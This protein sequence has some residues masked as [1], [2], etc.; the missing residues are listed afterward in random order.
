[1]L[2]PFFI[3]LATIAALG[4]S[5]TGQAANLDTGSRSVGKGASQ[6]TAPLQFQLFCLKHPQDC[7]ASSRSV[8][9]YT[10]KVRSMLSN[11]NSAVNR[12][13]RPLRERRDKWSLNPAAGDCDDYVMTKRHRLINAGIPASAL[14]VAMVRTR[15]GEGHAILVVKTSSGDYV[16]DNLR[17]SIVKRQQTGYRMVSMASANPNRWN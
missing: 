10:P 9:S 5:S 3:A 8:I 12:S 14:R 1:M 11:V 6:N 17:R 2:K 13:I 16:L 15:T 4:A 7:R